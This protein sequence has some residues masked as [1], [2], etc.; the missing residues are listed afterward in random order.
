MFK[1]EEKRQARNVQLLIKIQ[2]LYRMW[3]KRS[4]YKKTRKAQITIASHYRGYKAHKKYVK[5]RTAAILLQSYMRM[6]RERK[7]FL[8]IKYKDRDEQ[9][10][11][12]RRATEEFEQR[13]RE[14]ADAEERRRAVEERR[15]RV[16]SCF[17]FC[18][19]LLTCRLQ[20]EAEAAERRRIEEMRRRAAARI[21]AMAKGWLVRKRTRALFRF[22]LLH[23]VGAGLTGRAGKTPGRL[24]PAMWLCSRSACSS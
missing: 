1:L 9:R 8:K 15:L 3:K 16:R 13:M 7:A 22:V 19:D 23:W 5:M 24:W 14:D 4:L 20:E 10:A 21:V 12:E 18:Q 17:A 11:R 2:T 6:W